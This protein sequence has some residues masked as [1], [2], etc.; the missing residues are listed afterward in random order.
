MPV[1]I[2]SSVVT[3][4]QIIPLVGPLLEWPILLIIAVVTT[5]LQYRM[6]RVVHGL[7]SGRA[8]GAVLVP[9]V[10]L[11]CLCLPI[12]VIG[13]L[14]VMGPIIGNTFSSINQSLLTP[15]P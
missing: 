6:V 13:G 15:V 5:I 8:V 12:V 11:L 9:F 14:M 7:T 10:L 3:F 2:V 1:G 4:L